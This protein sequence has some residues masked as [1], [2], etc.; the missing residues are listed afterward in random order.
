MN[1]SP[2][3]YELVEHLTYL[4]SLSNRQYILALKY[5]QLKNYIE[6]IDISFVKQVK[7]NIVT[8]EDLQLF[9]ERIEQDR[10]DQIDLAIDF[11]DS[12]NK[13]ELD[14]WTCLR[15][16]TSAMAWNQN[17]GRNLKFTVKLNGK[18][19][20]ILSFGSDIISIGSRDTYIGWDKDAKFK[21]G[22]LKSIAIGSTIVPSQPFGYSLCGGK[23]LSLLIYNEFIRNKWEQKYNDALVGITTT[24]LFGGDS[25]QYQGM[26][27]YWKSLS[28]TKGLIFLKP[29]V[30][31]YKKMRARLTTEYRE[32]LDKANAVSGPKDKSIKLYY[33]KY[34]IK[35]LWKEQTGGSFKELKA[36]HKR[37][38]Y[39]SRF[40]N[41]SLQFLRD[42]VSRDQLILRSGLDFD[43]QDTDGIIKYWWRKFAKKRFDK[44]ISFEGQFFMD[45]IYEIDTVEQFIQKYGNYKDKEFSFK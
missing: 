25:N 16:F 6:N 40:Y 3:D 5:E 38:V 10:F 17:P 11:A 19:L 13:I 36:E 41:N 32:D 2:Q 12:S 18:Y 45:D 37:G 31:Y 26:P 7:G 20:G 24:S 33:D 23:F 39:F 22:K 30:E 15:K 9:I 42:Q 4:K 14:I 34:D 1:W 28:E 27:K 35:T 44:D 8:K 43:Y 29:T 21:K